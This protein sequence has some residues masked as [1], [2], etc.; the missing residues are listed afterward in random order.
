[1]AMNILDYWGLPLTLILYGIFHVVH[2]RHRF[3]LLHP[4]IL[5]I[6]MLIIF[7]MTTDIPFSSYN[8]GGQYI[9]SILGLCIVVLAVPMF[10]T[11]DL[12][13]K[14]LRLMI[15]TSLIGVYTSFASLLFLGSVFHLPKFIM[16]SLV[17][18]SITTAMAIEGINLTGGE[19]S[20][21]VLGVMV[22][23]ISGAIIGRFVLT[24]TGVTD[25]IARGCAL[26]MASHV[27]GTSQALE[28]GSIT[29]SFSALSIPITGI[30]TILHLPLF[31]YLINR[32]Y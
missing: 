13:L 28:E 7:L 27:M 22:T 19:V 14:N 3:I 20:I 29:G 26:G 10:E 21:A 4:N 15:V 5:S 6:L 17:P 23:G 32:W 18:K 2:R 12:L 16:L 31:A 25:P 9:T 24:K 8:E 11:V 1:M 30:M